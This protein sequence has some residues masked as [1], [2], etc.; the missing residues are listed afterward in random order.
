MTSDRKDM[1]W[2][3][4]D[5]TNVETIII[6]NQDH[7]NRLI[8]NFS[9]DTIHC[10]QGVYANGGMKKVRRSLKMYGARWGAIMEMVDERPF[11]WPIKRI[12]YRRYLSQWVARPDFILAIGTKTT[13][14]V[15][16]RGFLPKNTFPFTYF[17]NT[18][19]DKKID[20]NLTN[21]LFRIGFVGQ[22]IQL[23]RVDLLIEALSSL[24]NQKFELVII[25]DGPLYDVLKFQAIERL[26]SNRLSMLGQLN[27][28]KVPSVM[29][30]LDCFVLPS[31]YDGWGVVVTEALMAGIPVISSD[32]CGSSEAVIASGVGGVFPK[33]NVAALQH[34]LERSILERGISKERSIQLAHWAKC[35]GDKAGAD[36]FSEIA[37]FV[38]NGGKKPV[39]PWLKSNDTTGSG[40]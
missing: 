40:F 6:K 10:V 17:I 4:P 16:N 22:L 11:Y 27:M 37:N 36:Y 13:D 35:L 14:W 33:G 38:Y 39:P 3:E 18:Y 31:D 2:E 8:M 9:I 12:I 30:S 20:L 34:L 32:A 29:K 5:N 21:G 24:L 7:I 25:G 15:K 23:K 26:G 28:K 1:G 19:S